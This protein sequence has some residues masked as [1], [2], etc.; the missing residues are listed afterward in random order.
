MTTEET[1]T[2]MC[3]ILMTASGDSYDLLLNDRSPCDD[4]GSGGDNDG[5]RKEFG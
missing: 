4:D 5:F 1:A 3:T 2:L